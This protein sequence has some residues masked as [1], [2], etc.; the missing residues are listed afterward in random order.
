MWRRSEK[1]R[2][3]ARNFYFFAKKRFKLLFR[4]A[5]LNLDPFQ[6]RHDRDQHREN[7]GGSADD[8]GDRLSEEYA[9]GSHMHGVGE[10]VGQ[11]YDDE[12]FAEQG[13][14]DRKDLLVQGFKYRLTDVLEVHK[15]KSRKIHVQR[16]NRILDQRRVRAENTDQ[17]FRDEDDHA[18]HDGRVAENKETHDQNGFPHASRSAGTIVVAQDRGSSLY[19]GVNRCLDKLAHTG[20]DGHDR[21]IDIAAGDGKDIVAADRHEAVG[22]LHDKSGRAEAENVS[23]MFRTFRDLIF[24]KEP[25]LQLGFFRE[26]KQDEGCGQALGDHSGDGRAADAESEGKNKERIKHKVGSGTDRDG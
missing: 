7:A 1:N 26:E 2:S 24:M 17:R 12:Y 18:P 16:R 11:R 23:R 9:V 3:S 13:E 10:K 21:D 19:H 25:Q 5:V 20:D 4:L 14:E 8:I 22:E 6:L 15:D